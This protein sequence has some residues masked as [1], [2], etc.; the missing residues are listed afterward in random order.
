[1]CLMRTNPN[2]FSRDV[3]QLKTIFSQSRVRPEAGKERMND[4]TTRSEGRLN[5]SW[6]AGSVGLAFLLG[7]AGPGCSQPGSNPQPTAS[8]P[9]PTSLDDYPSRPSMRLATLPGQLQSKSSIT[10]H[11]PL[12][13]ML[14]VYVDQPQTNLAA[15]FVWAEF[16]PDILAAEA[17]A[18]EEARVKMEQREQLQLELEI[19][20]QRM[21]LEKE[22]EEASRQY[23]MLQLLSTNSDLAQRAFSVPGH[24]FNPLKPGALEQA[25]SELGFLTQT[26][27]F[28]AETNLVFMGIDLPGQRSEWQRQKLQFDRRQAQARLTMPFDGQL[29]VNLPLTEGVEEYPVTLGQELGVARNLE[30]I[31]LRMTLSN[32]AW[33]GLSPERLFAVVRLPYGQELQASFAFQKIERAQM[34]EESIYYFEFPPDKAPL[35]ARLMGTDIT[36]ELWVTLPRQARIVPKLSLVMHHPQVFQGQGWAMGVAEVWP[37]THLLVEGQTDVAVWTPQ[38]AM[39][40]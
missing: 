5:F 9:P 39:N 33:A 19:P 27:D 40:R 34:R 6:L 36:C 18:L 13:G 2:F 8:N 31:R 21:R 7:V 25:R 35:A 26:L 20:K 4:Q 38:T 11:A 10:V 22:F 16:E 30:T 12:P 37:G 32:P 17:E 24:K 29:T 1:M 3:M 28:L 15:G 23:S 14:R